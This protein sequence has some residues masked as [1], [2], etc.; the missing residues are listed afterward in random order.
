MGR[1]LHA[2]RLAALD[3]NWKSGNV[4]GGVEEGRIR[5]G[6]FGTKVPKAVQDEVLARRQKDIA[7]DKLQPFRA[8]SADV[9]GKD[10]CVMIAEGAQLNDERIPTLNWLVEGVQGRVGR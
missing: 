10:D 8:V 6:D 4:W 7:V 9:R 3:G 5:D 2:T 1:Q